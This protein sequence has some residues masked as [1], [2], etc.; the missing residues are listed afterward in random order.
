MPAAGHPLIEA[1]LA[2]NY[3]WG[4]LKSRYLDPVLKSKHGK[5]EELVIMPYPNYGNQ[6][7]SVNAINEGETERINCQYT[8]VTYKGFPYIFLVA[9]SLI[10]KDSE[11]L[12][13]YGKDYFQARSHCDF[14]IPGLDELTL[15]MSPLSDPPVQWEKQLCAQV[16][17]A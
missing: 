4:G 17:Y 5:E 8:G 7:M 11:L 14:R 2:T 16:H 9:T 12:T 10:K 6:C 1:V 13:D 15:G 3:E